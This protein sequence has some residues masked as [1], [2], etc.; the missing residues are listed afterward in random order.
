MH[1]SSSV[2]PLAIHF[3]KGWNMD[4]FKNVVN[5]MSTPRKI[6]ITRGRLLGAALVMTAC[7]ATPMWAAPFFFTTGSPNG[8]LA[9]LSRRA[10]PGKVETETADDFLLQETTVITQA[11][12]FGLIPA[13]TPLDNI[14][15]VEVE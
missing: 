7:L 3:R 1:D 14:R 13:G 8:L 9:A 12:I 5:A 10:S 4:K 6:V 11:T 2:E 15:D